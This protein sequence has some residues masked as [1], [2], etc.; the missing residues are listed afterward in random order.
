MVRARDKEPP[1]SRKD[2]MVPLDSNIAKGPGHRHDILL[3][4]PLV[5]ILPKDM[6]KVTGVHLPHADADMP[7]CDA[8]CPMLTQHAPSQCPMSHADAACSALT[9]HAPHMPWLRPSKA[10]LTFSF[11]SSA[12]VSLCCLLAG[13]LGLFSPASEPTGRLRLQLW[14]C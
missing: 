14:L 11:D 1:N 10:D 8:A 2:K 9:Q 3:G 6:C 13:L 5:T 4:T 7:H 12:P